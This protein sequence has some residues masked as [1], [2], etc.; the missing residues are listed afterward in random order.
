MAISHGI[1]IEVSEKFNR[2]L[3]IKQLKFSARDLA[4]NHAI[5]ETAIAIAI[6][7]CERRVHANRVR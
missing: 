5:E 2:R 1:A 3:N 6:W 7:W 4:Q